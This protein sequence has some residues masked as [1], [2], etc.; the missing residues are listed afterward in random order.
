MKKVKKKKKKKKRVHRRSH[1]LKLLDQAEPGL[2]WLSCSRVP[3]SITESMVCLSSLLPGLDIYYIHI[4]LGTRV[5][6][7]S[8]QEAQIRFHRLG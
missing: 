8:T 6:R 7:A 2:E 3:K 4:Y 5:Y 1:T